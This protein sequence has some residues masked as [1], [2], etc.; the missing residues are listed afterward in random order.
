MQPIPESAEALRRLS[1]TSGQDLVEQLR[2]AANLV[3]QAVP[4]CVAVSFSHFDDELTFT[5]VAPAGEFRLLVAGQE[6]DEVAAAVGSEASVTGGA[7]HIDESLLLVGLTAALEEVRSSLSL[8]LQRHGQ[9]Y[10]RLDLYAGNDYAF[11]GREEALATMFNAAV[12]EVAYDADLHMAP[13]AAARK[14][15][16]SLDELGLIDEAV[17]ALMVRKLMPFKPAYRSLMEA[18]DRAR[19][20]PVDLAALVV[21]QR[22]TQ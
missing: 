21:R 16:Q 9:T 4:D 1:V 17:G 2:L 20:S 15:P 6:R 13:F 8:S 14:T 18:A 10:G 19:V 7:D 11:V 22:S 3:V 5:L 12:Q